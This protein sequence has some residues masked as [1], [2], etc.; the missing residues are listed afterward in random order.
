MRS[1]SFSASFIA[2]QIAGSCRLE[3]IPV[4]AQDEKTIKNIVAG[5]VNAA[6]LRRALVEQYQSQN[7][8]TLE[9]AL[10]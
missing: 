10:G 2:A 5:R 9:L 4:T 3:G 8:A 6:Q 1:K 7:R